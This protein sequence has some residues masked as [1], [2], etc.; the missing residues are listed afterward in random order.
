MIDVEKLFLDLKKAVK[1]AGFFLLSQVVEVENH[2]NANDLLTKNDMATEEFLLK[3]L[4]TKYPEVNVISEEFNPNVPL[5][6][7]SVVIDPIDGTCNYAAGLD[8]FGIQV[9]IFNENEAVGSIIYLPK[10]KEMFFA[11]KNKGCFM[12]N[13]RIEVDKEKLAKDGI[14][15]LS[16]FYKDQIVKFES[17]YDLVKDLHDLYLKT[18]LLGAAC[19]D[20]TSL[21]K[22]NAITYICNY[23]NIWDIAPGLLLAKEAGCVC[24]SLVN[25]K[26]NYGESALIVSNNLENLNLVLN[27][28]KRG[29]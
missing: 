8:L 22:G 2:K 6:G 4:K 14:L 3:F 25:E 7:I 20:F 13:K 5:K 11:F 12:N 28:Y 23:S 16:D 9:A 27:T 21:V 10:K 17:Q 29:K 1:K 24:A 26:Y 18:R 15:I 19:I